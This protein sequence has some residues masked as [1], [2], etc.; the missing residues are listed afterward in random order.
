MK[1]PD[2][3]MYD[4]GEVPPCSAFLTNSNPLIK[5]G[6]VIYKNLN[7][8]FFFIGTTPTDEN[9]SY[10]IST[11]LQINL[12]TY[13]IGL[14]I[15]QIEQGFIKYDKNA[16]ISTDKVINQFVHESLQN[17]PTIKEEFN[18][19]LALVYSNGNAI[20]DPLNY[21]VN[22]SKLAYYV[23]FI[24]DRLTFNPALF[25]INN[26]FSLEN[27]LNFFS[28]SLNIQFPFVEEDD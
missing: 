20:L 6:K 10:N 4:G 14:F 12:S 21:S 28:A 18:A 2:C 9:L 1:K 24:I 26:S 16:V 15:Y 23:L 7:R 5:D 3:G 27:C 17:P 19:N 11:N 22:I 13:V 25:F 8:I